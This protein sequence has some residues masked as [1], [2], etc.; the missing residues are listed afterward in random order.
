MPFF[1]T[2]A[3]VLFIIIHSLEHNDLHIHVFMAALLNHC[4]VFVSIHWAPGVWSHILIQCYYC[5]DRDIDVQVHFKY[6][7]LKFVCFLF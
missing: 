4:P 2:F 6:K 7:L 3:M 5:T 1:C